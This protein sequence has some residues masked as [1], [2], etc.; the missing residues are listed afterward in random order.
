LPSSSPGAI[1]LA[2]VFTIGAVFFAL[3]SWMIRRERAA[4]LAM[5]VL[6]APPAAAPAWD[7]WARE[8]GGVD[9]PVDRWTRL[10]MIERLAI[11]GEP[12]CVETL[13]RA[14]EEDSDAS[15]RDA[16]DSA[17]LVIGARA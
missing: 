15:I 10:D 8:I 9:E 2:V 12:W 14:R 3:G 1:V 11:V 5:P 13:E 6:E 7:G 4:K 17:L 16:A